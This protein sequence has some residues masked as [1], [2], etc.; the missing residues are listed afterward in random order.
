MLYFNICPI[1]ILAFARGFARLCFGYCCKV[2]YVFPEESKFPSCQIPLKLV[3]Q[4]SCEIKQTVHFVILVSMYV[5][6][7]RNK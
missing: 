4:F 6:H 3:Q 1:R 7:K 2:A 5:Y